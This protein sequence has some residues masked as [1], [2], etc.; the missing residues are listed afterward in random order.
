[1]DRR[2]FISMV[3]GSILAGPL[4]GGAQQAGKVYR[5]GE[6]L[7][8][9]DK[10]DTFRQSLREL[11]FE[12]GRNLAIDYRWHEG[13]FDRL[14]ALVAELVSSSRTS[15]SCRSTSQPPRSKQQERRSH[16][17]RSS[18]NGRRL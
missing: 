15:S 11:G 7:T 5:V 9:Y 10:T 4:A 8:Q 2:A 16:C 6:L 17:L 18:R 1:M 13:K 12:E 14:P 3:G